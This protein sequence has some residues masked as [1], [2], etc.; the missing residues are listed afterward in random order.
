MEERVE[1]LERRVEE[2][3][4]FISV[5]L[6]NYKLTDSEHKQVYEQAVWDLQKYIDSKL[7]F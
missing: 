2:L 5:A 3:S 1:I 4:R 7:G 6:N